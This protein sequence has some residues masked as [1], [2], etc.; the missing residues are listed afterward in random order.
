MK[1]CPKCGEDPLNHCSKKCPFRYAPALRDWIKLPEELSVRSK[2]E[3][4]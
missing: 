3:T 4:R 2:E 1:K